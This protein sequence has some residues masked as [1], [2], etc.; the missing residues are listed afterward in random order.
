MHSETNWIG[1]LKLSGE[2]PRALTKTDN[3]SDDV[4]MS[5]FKWFV[6]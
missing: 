4:K 2:I 6:R 1:A 3:V 5:Y